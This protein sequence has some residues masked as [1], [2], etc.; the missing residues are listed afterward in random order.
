MD[1]SEV[2]K[3]LG[4]SWTRTMELVRGS[5]SS[6]ISLLSST[7]S[8]ILSH[9]GKQLR[10]MLC[11]LMARACGNGQ[12]NSDSECYAA[13]SELLHNATLLHDDV[14][15]KSAMRRGFPTV[16]S[17]LGPSVA[18][19]VG[20]FWLAR[21]VELV[22]ATQHRDSVVKLFSKTLTDLSEGEMLQ[23]QKAGE[24]DTTEEDYYRIIYCK[25]GSL[26][27]ASCVSGAISVGA[28][29]F[30]RNAASNY[31]CAM[32][33]AFQ[34]KDDILDYA[35]KEELGKPTGADLLERKI[36]LPLLGAM[37]NASGSGYVREMV[38]NIP[39]HPEY[40]ASIREFVF[41][42]GGIEYAS[43]KLD[44][45]VGDALAALEV[46]PDSRDRD[47]LEEIARY[48]SS[49]TI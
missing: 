31:A 5:L 45:F 26:F 25:T 38:K 23:L 22:I 27:S 2:L 33:K 36:T 37:Y 28:D 6:D 47:F 1:R 20:D 12:T 48:N 7:N 8:S 9:S 16:A 41:S 18:V 35:G 3:Y 19:L 4:G 30:F 40:V 13:A 39:S 11:L 46:L 32:G 43:A 10:P 21:A 17:L 24:G 44:E 49:R 14:A 15:D 42:N 34:I 29:D